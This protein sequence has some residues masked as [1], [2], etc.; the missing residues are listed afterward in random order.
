MGKQ[1]RKVDY[2]VSVIAEYRE[3][4]EGQ[5]NNKARVNG[6]NWRGYG[7]AAMFTSE[8]SAQV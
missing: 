1:T 5:R 4:K 7:A 3:A 6:N 2:F 8:G